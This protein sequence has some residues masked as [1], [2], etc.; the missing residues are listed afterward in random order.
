MGTVIVA[1]VAFSIAF[2]VAFLRAAARPR[3]QFPSEHED[4]GEQILPRPMA[5]VNVNASTDSLKQSSP[6]VACSTH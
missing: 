1:W 2:C 6:E 3:P 4:Q 5:K